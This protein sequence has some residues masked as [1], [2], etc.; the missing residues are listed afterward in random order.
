M[1]IKV[2]VIGA[3]SVGA[4]IAY[5]LAMGSTDVTELVLID[6]NEKK[7]RGEVLDIAHGMSFRDPIT[8][9]AGSYNDA[10][11]SDIVIITSGVA[12]KP[13]QTRLELAQ[14]NVNIIKDIAPQIAAAAP[15]AFYL[16]VSNP[17]D[18]LTY[19]FAKISG[20]P[21]NRIIGTGTI[22][23]TSRLHYALSQHYHIAQK[24]V[25]AYVFGEHG[26]SS[27]I[28]WS[29]VHIAGMTVGDYERA[30]G[31]AADGGTV[32]K[33]GGVSDDRALSEHSV[34]SSG[35][36]K[37]ADRKVALTCD[38]VTDDVTSLNCSKAADGSTAA[39]C[40]TVS[41]CG[42]VP[43]EDVWETAKGQGAAATPL[44]CE[45]MSAYIRNCGARVIAGKGATFYA[46]SSA[47]LRICQ[48]LTAGGDSVLPVSTMLHGEY[49]IEDV[50][51]SILTVLGPDG[52]KGHLEVPLTPEELEKL[53]ASAE[54]MRCALPKI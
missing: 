24:D 37:T 14:T 9:V 22:L 49:G 29:C 10:A 46:I 50:C 30:C 23:D 41:D 1:S 13:G 27:F 51:I 40:G 45:R 12:R 34:M 26:D 8:I 3:G 18:I 2:T 5:T 38:A 53:R 25:Q 52:V 4:S 17:V 15:D 48:I 11:G 7:A 35:C 6:I 54:A 31:I 16:I 43:E 47:V 33:Y 32:S 20:I 21:E 44:D 19:V 36:S 39:E 28:P 42:G